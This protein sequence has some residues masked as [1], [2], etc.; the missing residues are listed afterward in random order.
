MEKLAIWH[1][2]CINE[3]MDSNSAVNTVGDEERGRRRTDVL[4][5]LNQTKIIIDM[6]F[7]DI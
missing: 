6:N 4:T 1:Y 2:I 5:I 3:W 7:L